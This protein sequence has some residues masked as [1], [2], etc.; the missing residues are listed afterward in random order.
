LL[1]NVHDEVLAK[2][3]GCGLVAP[4]L[5]EGARILDLGSGS[6]RDA[7]V[8]AQLVGP[9]G[10]VV[11]VDMTPEQIAVARRHL[12]WHRERFGFAQSN[13]SFIEGDIENL[14]ALGLEA[15]DFDVI[16]SNCVLNLASDKPRVLRD[17]PVLLGE[18]WAARCTGTISSRW[19][20][21][22]GF[23]IRAWWRTGR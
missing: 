16:V 4:S 8:L 1:G 10:S 6:G 23:S 15:D 11:G 3:Y 18:C 14:A 20:S 7:Y 13:V 17:D 22:Q 2:Y 19:R 5:L 12:D 9:T 21:G